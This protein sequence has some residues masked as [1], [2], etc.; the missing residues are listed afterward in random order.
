MPSKTIVYKPSSPNAKKL[1][2]VVTVDSTL[3]GC[4]IFLQQK[5]R[6]YSLYLAGNREIVDVTPVGATG[7][8]T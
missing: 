1:L 5:M 6:Q 3:F 7:D 4:T 8:E 2:P